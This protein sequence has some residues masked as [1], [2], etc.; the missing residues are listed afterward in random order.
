MK[1]EKEKMLSGE[2][3]DASDPELTKGRRNA[4][5]LF[6]QLNQSGKDDP[7]LRATIL[8]RL[9]GG[10][11]APLWI[12]PPFFCDYGSNIFLGRNVYFNFNCVILDVCRVTI[13]SDCLFGPAVQIYT[14]THPQNS[15]TRASGAEFGVPVTI[16]DRVWVGGGAIICPGVAVGDRS[17]ITAGAV[18][19]K[20]VP[21]GVM[22]GGNP[23][24]IIKD[25]D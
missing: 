21:T 25:V 15:R 6:R 14:A 1:T 18:V 20:D 9:L 5:L 7:E 8:N 16:G 11:E 3:Y 10:F 12:E 4:R 13:G 17:I 19:T 23:A 24:R 22:M 2:L